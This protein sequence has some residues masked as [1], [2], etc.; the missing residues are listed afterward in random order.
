MLNSK[1][2][3]IR[4]PLIHFPGSAADSG[5]VEGPRKRAYGHDRPPAL[6]ALASL[7][8]RPIFLGVNSAY[9]KNYPNQGS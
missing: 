6:V 8:L 2:I 5:G 7:D 3:G 9:A 1:S 4:V